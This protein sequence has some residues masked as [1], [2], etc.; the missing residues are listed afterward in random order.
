MENPG[1]GEEILHKID[2]LLRHFEFSENEKN[3][4]LKRISD[5]A[6]LMDDG[7]SEEER[8]EIIRNDAAQWVI[9]GFGKSHYR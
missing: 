9:Q 4:I 1:Y 5:L 2:S 6:V 8:A 7:F 3:A